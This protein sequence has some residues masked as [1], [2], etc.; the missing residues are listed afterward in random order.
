[1]KIDRILRK[2]GLLIV[3]FILLLVSCSPRAGN[4]SGTGNQL[5]ESKLTRVTD[6]KVPEADLQELSAGNRAF[7]ARLYQ[8]LRGQDGNLFFSPY[9]ISLA[10][11]MTFAG[12]Q[13]ETAR[14]MASTMYYTLPPVRLH[15]AFNSLDQYLEKMGQPEQ[16]PSPN[17]SGQGFQ[18]SIANSIW[19]QRDFN[20][21]QAYLDLLAQNYG[22]GMRLVDFK[23]AP[24]ISRQAINDWVSQHTKEKIKDLFPQGTIDDSTRLVLANAIY[25]KASW[26]YP[27]VE[28]NTREGIFHLK[29]GGEVSVPMMSFSLN[30]SSVA[31]RY[32]RGDIFQAV[33]LPY[34]DRKTMMVVVLPDEGKFDS[35]E[36]GLDAARLDMVLKGLKESGMEL[37]MPKFKIESSFSLP[38]TLVKM[39]MIDAFG[40]NADFSGMDGKRDLYI[41]EVLHKAVVTVDEK[42]TEAAAATGVA[43]ATSGMANPP[44]VHIDRPFLFFIYEQDRGTILFTGRV[45]NP[46]E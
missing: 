44:V 10:L 38:K 41:S 3:L 34:L 21:L 2:F 12:A 45:M 1:M 20:F 32:E 15:P 13:G 4:I 29:S 46:M 5:A 6:P 8:Q 11:A 7:A 30:S 24:E 25:F 31:T 43:I 35:F 39:G 23:G 33:G 37:S 22:V 36:S 9:S 42:G 26:M 14:Q 28:P 19:G 27:F 40:S 17:D 16:T 18:L